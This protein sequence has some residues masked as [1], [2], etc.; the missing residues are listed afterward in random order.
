[1]DDIAKQLGISK[2]TI[3]QHFK[4][5]NELINILIS[6]IINFQHH[7]MILN[8]QAE[9]AVQEALFSIENINSDLLQKN[10]ILFYDL[11]KYHYE[12]WLKFKSFKDKYISKFILDNLERGISEGYYRQDIKKEII[13]AMRLEQIDL[14]FTWK[15]NFFFGNYSLTQVMI[16]ITEHYLYGILNTK[17]LAYIN[18]YKGKTN[19][20]LV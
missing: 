20:K 8:R 9:N 16:E 15:T 11:Q 18:F 4:D 1:M 13:M 12:A 5:K 17:G 7:K 3:Y 19:H 10:P 2:K 6:D 14:L